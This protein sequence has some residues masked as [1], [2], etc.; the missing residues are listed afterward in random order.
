MLKRQNKKNRFKVTI[1]LWLFRRLILRVLFLLLDQEVKRRSSP[2]PASSPSRSKCEIFHAEIPI[3]INGSRLPYLCHR[4]ER[5]FSFCCWLKIKT[6]A[7]LLL[8]FFRIKSRSEFLA[9]LAG[10]LGWHPLR[11][12]TDHPVTAARERTYFILSAY[13]GTRVS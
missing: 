9:Q 8:F 3:L 13:A 5:F 2:S 7:F 10:F 6:M 11:D 4:R 1:L 12:V